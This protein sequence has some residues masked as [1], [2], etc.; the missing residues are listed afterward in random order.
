RLMQSICL[1]RM[2]QQIDRK[3]NR[4]M[5]ELPPK[6]EVVR[7]LE[8]A[9]GERRLYQMAEDI[10]RNKYQNMSRSGTVLKN[11]MSILQIILRLRQLC[12]HPRLWS[13][14]KWKEAH[15]LAADAAIA[16]AHTSQLPAN[17]DATSSTSVPSVPATEPKPQPEAKAEA[18]I[19]AKIEA[20]AEAKPVAKAE[21]KPAA[22]A[23][24]KVE[25]KPETKPEA[26]LELK[27]NTKPEVAP[28]RETKPTRT[29]IA[30][31]LCAAAMASSDLLDESDPLDWWKLEA[32]AHGVHVKCGYC[33]ECAI[34]PA[35]LP[36]LLRLGANVFP[37]PGITK[38]NHIACRKCQTILF[39]AAPASIKERDALLAGPAVNTLSECVLCGEMLGLGDVTHL[40]VKDILQS[41]AAASGDALATSSSDIPVDPLSPGAAA[42]ADINKD[43]EELNR[44]CKSFDSSTKANALI[45]DIDKIR[46]RQWVTDSDFKVDQSHPAVQARQTELV[47]RPG[48]REKCVVFSQWTSM[49]D[50]IQPLLRQRNIRFT[51]LDGKMQRVQRD[52]NLA[53]FKTDPEIEVLLL[54]LRA[55][56]V[57]LNLAYA[58]HVF[59]MDA[60]WN[61]SVESQAIDRIH[62]LGQKNPVTVTRYFIKDSI[63]ER[64]LKLQT[65]KAKV[66][67]ISLMDSTRFRDPNADTD[68]ALGNE[69]DDDGSL[70]I[71]TGTHSRQQ[72]LDDLNMLFG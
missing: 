57:G 16:D 55:G 32:S 17:G 10:A 31:D 51:R 9:E 11:Y 66:A 50:L 29:H 44:Q 34:P 27:P 58:T 8:L 20:K 5:I 25:A 52:R 33:G 62:R 68:A 63:E 45:N 56:G 37:G 12:T 22:K 15:V 41:L 47:L 64:I 53:L 71:T 43:Y 70:A 67:D 35:M 4:T 65:R 24:A 49:L 48:L 1:R 26:M 2:K 36:N 18:N 30:A 69:T 39:G 21:A 72:R 19:G 46:A 38:C 60:F 40:S 61:P 14:D 54:S 6:F 3:T 13:E 7:W 59:L 28:K 42:T 23:E